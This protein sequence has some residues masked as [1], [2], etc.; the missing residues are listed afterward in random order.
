[1]VGKKWS[2]INCKDKNISY[3]NEEGVR[4]EVQGVKIPLKLRPITSSQQEK[5]IRKGCQFYEV[6]VGNRNP[7]G[8]IST[9]GNLPIVQDFTDAFPEEIFGLPPKRDIDFTTE[10][11]PRAT[12]V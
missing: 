2:D 4:Q 1:M 11:F 9:L 8:M 10:I 6:K 7:K 3:L 12:R 5:S